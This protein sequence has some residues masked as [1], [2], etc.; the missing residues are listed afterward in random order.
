MVIIVIIA[1]ECHDMGAQG[2]KCNQKTGQCTCKK[3]V[4][5][6]TCNQC[7]DGS[8]S[9]SGTGCKLCKCFEDRSIDQLC[10]KVK[11]NINFA[12]VLHDIL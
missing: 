2:I 1:C 5:G 7:E 6:R 4:S 3:R 11:I 12:V 10:N 8:H 9:L